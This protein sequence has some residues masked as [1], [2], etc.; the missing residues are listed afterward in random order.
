MFQGEVGFRRHGQEAFDETGEGDFAWGAFH[1]SGL[2]R[3]GFEIE[4]VE[5][6]QGGGDLVLERREEGSRVFH[7]KELTFWK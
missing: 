1:K 5:F 4:L 2:A 6:G 7:G 3:E